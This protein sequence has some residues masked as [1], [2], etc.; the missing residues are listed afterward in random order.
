MNM[1]IINNI[2]ANNIVNMNNNKCSSY[3]NVIKV[4]NPVNDLSLKE[5]NHSRRLRGLKEFTEE[6]WYN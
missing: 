4:S 5:V 2:I 1:M 6:E 3:P